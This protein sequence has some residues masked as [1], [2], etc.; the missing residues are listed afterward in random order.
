MT[1]IT[2]KQNS[3]FVLKVVGL[4]PQPEGN[5]TVGAFLGGKL[6]GIASFTRYN[7]LKLRYRGHIGSVYVDEAVRGQGIGQALLE[8][9]IARVKQYGGLEQLSLTV[10]AGQ[11]AAQRLYRRL[12]FKTS[13]TEHRTLRVGDTY[14]TSSTFSGRQVS[15]EPGWLE[16][17][18][19]VCCSSAPP[20]P[21]LKA[22]TFTKKPSIPSGLRVVVRGAFA[23]RSGM[24]L[25]NH[26]LQKGFRGATR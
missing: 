18:S 8:A 15:T 25:P 5:F 13:C 6:V 11:A 17:C 7:A 10:I 19:S 4:R 3:P 22:P 21:R 20:Q 14:L 1:A 2:E 26:P 12:G 9:L 16:G 24:P 23:L